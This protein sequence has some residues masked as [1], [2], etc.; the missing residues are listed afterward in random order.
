MF[1]NLYGPKRERR[2][3]ACSGSLMALDTTLSIHLGGEMPPRLVRLALA[4]RS[5]HAARKDA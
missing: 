2:Y 5:P 3:A 1:F 4:S